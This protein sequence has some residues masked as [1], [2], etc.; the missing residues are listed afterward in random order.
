[1]SVNLQEQKIIQPVIKKRG[2]P[3]KNINTNIIDDNLPTI[4]KN[5]IL[6]L[7]I[8]YNE[9][10]EYIKNKLN[11]M[12]NYAANIKSETLSEIDNKSIISNDSM[13]SPV[14]N[15]EISVPRVISLNT[16]LTNNNIT[17]QVQ[18]NDIH[19]PFIKNNKLEIP[20]ITHICCM[21]DNCKINR[22][23]IFLPVKFSKGI[24]YVKYWFCSLNC[25]CAFNLSL[26]D[27]KISERYGLLKFLYNINR[28]IEPSPNIFILNKYGGNMTKSEYRKKYC[29]DY[30]NELD[31]N[32]NLDFSNDD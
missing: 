28:C 23:P 29:Y 12:N 20:N 6:Y 15:K 22:K 4:E 8:N 30:D 9:Y 13:Y 27:D 21:W 11:I 10:Q 26:K 5:L 17:I 32:T 31:K 1:M 7:D 19:C 25:A 16:S 3:R 2:R 18:Q 24:I 14:N